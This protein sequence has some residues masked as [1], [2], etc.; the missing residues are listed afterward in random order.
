M[1]KVLLHTPDGVRD[2]Y[3]EE[4]SSKI[5][6]AEKI[7]SKMKSFGYQDIDHYNNDLDI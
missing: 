2:I 1:T 5:I 6:V 3:G 4:C 7:H